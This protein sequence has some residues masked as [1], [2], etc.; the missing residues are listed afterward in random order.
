MHPLPV[1]ATDPIELLRA[2]DGLYADDLLVAAV[3]HL[4]LF[5]SLAEDPCDLAELARRLGVAGRPAGVMCTL[6]P[7]RAGGYCSWA[8]L[9]TAS[10][11]SRTCPGVVSRATGEARSTPK[12]ALPSRQR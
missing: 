3:A 8:R 4:D 2:R 11:S 10:A 7:L 6:L 9:S 1:P 5:S 12:T